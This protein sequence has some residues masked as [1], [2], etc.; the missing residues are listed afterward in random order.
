MAD[1]ISGNKQR[2]EVGSSMESVSI[3]TMPHQEGQQVEMEEAVSHRALS[4]R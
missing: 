1:T 4:F 3:P 2:R